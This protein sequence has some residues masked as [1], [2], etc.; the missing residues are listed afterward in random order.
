MRIHISILALIAAV[1]LSGCIKPKITIFPDPSTEPLEEYTLEGKGKEKVLIIPIRGVISDTPKEQLLRQKPAVVQE[2]VSQL[3]RAE[4]DKDIKAVVLKVD[5]PGGTITASDILYHEIMEFKKRS[6]VKLVS[7]MMGVAASGGYYISLPADFILAHPTTV[8][9]SIG[10]VFIRPK[11]T[12]L[13]GKV[14]LDVEIEKHGKNKDMGSP[15]RKTT[16]E[17]RRIMQGLIDELGGRFISLVAHHR[18]LEE[19]ALADITTARVYLG[20]E[21]LRLG[22]VDRVGYLDGALSEAKKLAGLP[23]DA[24]VVVYRR[25]EYPDDNIYNSAGARSGEGPFSLINPGLPESLVSL[26]SGLYY[27]WLPGE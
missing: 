8:T 20:E 26:P 23:D 16:D 6:N 12:G 13:M 14:G 9:G 27:L 4:K 3:K 15:F 21:A 24:K 1:A 22:L 7:A 5:S 18:K 25:T 2:V 19:K 17:E 10:V 11:L